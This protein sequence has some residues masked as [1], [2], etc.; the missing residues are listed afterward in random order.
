MTLAELIQSQEFDSPF[1]IHPD[2]RLTDTFEERP[3]APSVYNGDE[4]QDIDIDCGPTKWRALRGLTGQSGYHGA[5]MHCSEYVGRGIADYMLR[6]V[7]D[8]EEPITFCIV[9]VE[10]WPEEDDPEPEPAGW[11][12]LYLDES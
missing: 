10:C 4:G 6:M 7:T 3:Y 9:V 1:T 8:S 5:V 2:G 11:A 12:I